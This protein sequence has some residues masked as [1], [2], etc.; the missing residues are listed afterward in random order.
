MGGLKMEAPKIVNALILLALI[1]GVVA[2]YANY[3]G[4]SSLLFICLGVGLVVLCI[5]YYLLE[6]DGDRK[7]G[8]KLENF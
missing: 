6:K 8:R 4:N 2:G 1:I 5:A 3:E 7:A